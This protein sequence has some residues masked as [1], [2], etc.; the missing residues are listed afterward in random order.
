[1]ERFF[2]AGRSLW[3]LSLYLVNWVKLGS[4]P[5]SVKS[6]TKP[7]ISS[8]LSEVKKRLTALGGR[9]FSNLPPLASPNLT[10]EG[11]AS[12]PE[13]WGAHR[14]LVFSCWQARGRTLEKPVG[15]QKTETGILTSRTLLM[16]GLAPFALDFRQAHAHSRP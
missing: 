16:Q 8:W 15:K 11:L 10:E 14:A 5:S 6:G 12:R 1:M 9:V 13:G 3:L 7:E 2:V 4:Y